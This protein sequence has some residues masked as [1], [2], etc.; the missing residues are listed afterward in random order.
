MESGS[1]REMERC[2]TGHIL[3]SGLRPIFYIGPL[4]H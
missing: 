2:Q 3:I 1:L 4:V